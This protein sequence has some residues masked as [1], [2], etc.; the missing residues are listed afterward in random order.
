MIQKV[1]VLL[2]TDEQKFSETDILSNTR[3]TENLMKIL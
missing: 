2:I 3:T 1:R